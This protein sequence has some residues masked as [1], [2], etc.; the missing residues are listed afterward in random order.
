MSDEQKLGGAALYLRHVEDTSVPLILNII[1]LE[2]VK[3]KNE[4]EAFTCFQAAAQQGYSKAQFNTAVCYEKGQGVKKD[5]DK[6]LY[7]YCQAA[8]RGHT[9]AQYRYAKLLLTS[10]GNQSLEEL[11][12]VINLLER[13]AAAGLTK[14]QVC[15]A[16]VYS[17]E[18][19]RDGSKSV[20]YLRMAA[21]SGD[22]NA[23]L[24]LGQCY[25]SGFGVQQN[26]TTANELYERAAQAGNK[27]AKKL[28]T[29]HSKDDAV[30]H[31]IHSSPCLSLTDH[32][33]QQ[34]LSHLARCVPLPTS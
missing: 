2:S 13:A 8:V 31:S 19:V 5:K 1:G 15:L 9:Q 21:E 24:F 12:T 26:L 22:D 34:P 18:P 16:S 23:L 6:A 14:A 11:N 17:Q 29:P 28:L 20:Q 33:L 10:R 7:Y 3:S 30:L 27:Q 4:E 32:W 25:E